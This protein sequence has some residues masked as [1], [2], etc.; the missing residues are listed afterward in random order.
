ML[1]KSMEPLFKHKPALEGVVVPTRC[2]LL[3]KEYS[4]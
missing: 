1:G 3:S 4:N 2:S